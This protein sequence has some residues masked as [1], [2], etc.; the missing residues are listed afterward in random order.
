M[1]RLGLA[2]LLLLPML[3]G[4]HAGPAAEL[5]TPDAPARTGFAFVA[6][7]DMGMGNEDQ[8]QVA[9]ALA[10]W[11]AANGCDFAIALGDLIYPAGA[12]DP[13]D[14]QFETKFERPYANVS[15]PFYM[16]LGNHDAS[17]D[18]LG[19]GT[20]AGVPVWADAAENELA[21]AR[22]TD[23]TSEKWTQPDR[24]YAFNATGA[25]FLALDTNL[26]L[27]YGLET[28][29]S[30]TSDIQDQEAWLPGAVAAMQ[31]PWRFA[32][33]HHPYVS[34]G[35]HGSAGSYD[36]LPM[37]GYNGDHLKQVFEDVLCDRVDLYFAGHDHNLQW[38]QPVPSCGRTQ[39]IVSAGGGAALYTLDGDEPA[40]W[41]AQSHGFFWL[42]VDG[43][44]LRIV[45]VG[46]DGQVLHDGN[47][48]KE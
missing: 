46:A 3:A 5:P 8:A 18:P 29:P 2:G 27:W 4:C 16:A 44:T 45:A 35:E 28:P 11:C 19:T 25:D 40:V 32:F 9:A 24:Y 39:F 15:F 47:I 7:G 36:G 43:P 30:L 23:R 10:S 21:Y 13:Y 34:N 20:T 26:L 22:R 6:I 38:L 1:R 42:R 14:E 37:P 48:T 31:R 17:Q 33:G 12:S 41:Q